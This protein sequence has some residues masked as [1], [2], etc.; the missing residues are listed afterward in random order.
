MTGVEKAA[1]FLRAYDG[2][3]VNIMEVCGTHTAAIFKCGVR[4]LISPKIRLIS[5]PGCP[6]CVTPQGYIDKLL[7][8]ALAPGNCVLSFGDML[9]VPGDEGSLLSHRGD[10]ARFQVVYSPLQTLDLAEKNPD[11]RYV[12]AAVGFETTAPVYALLLEEAEKRGLQN[13]RLLTA[14]KTILPAM[15]FICA[16]EPHVDAF[17]CPGHVSSII[18]A[19][20]YREI[21]EKYNKPMCVAGFDGS[22]L[23]A[24]ISEI[25][26]EFAGC[27]A[28]VRNFYTEAVSEAGNKKAQ[29]I[30]ARYFEPGDAFWRGIGDIPGSGLY[31]KPEY[32]KYDAGSHGIGGT[33]KEPAGC[34]C[35]DVICGRLYPDRCPHFGRACT[36]EAPLGACMVSDEGSCSI[37]Y[38]NSDS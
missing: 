11:T 22:H 24:A 14:L 34:R 2:P 32:S 17:L 25:L 26:V 6:V 23:L 27:R 29:A 37:W 10:G 38:R 28:E 5:G 20:A 1:S 7:E 13:I 8:Y 21:C 35:A 9:K 31:L 18:G 16:T 36:P 33:E 30:L 4:S 3:P 19:G 12:M 15:D